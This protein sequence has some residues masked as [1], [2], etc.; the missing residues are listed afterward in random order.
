MKQ[1]DIAKSKKRGIRRQ[2]PSND[3]VEQNFQLKDP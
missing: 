3:V 1:T 2:N